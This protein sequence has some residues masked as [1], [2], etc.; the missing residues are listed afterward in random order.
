MRAN[1]E[2]FHT[3]L[4]LAESSFDGEDVLLVH[5]SQDKNNTGDG[6]Y[7]LSVNS[8]IGVENDARDHLQQW[9]R[10]LSHGQ[11]PPQTGQ[12]PVN[13]DLTRSQS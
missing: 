11:Y 4:A 5:D 3:A 6:R 8:S 1:R 9:E 12:P 10:R 2:H 13:R 7:R